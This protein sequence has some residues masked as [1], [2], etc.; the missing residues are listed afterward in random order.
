[1]KLKTIRLSVIAY[2]LTSLPVAGEIQNFSTRLQI[3]SAL[4]SYLDGSLG[5]PIMDGSAWKAEGSRV[6][7]SRLQERRTDNTPAISGSAITPKPVRW[8][9]RTG[10]AAAGYGAGLVIGIG[11]TR[12]GT[13]DFLHSDVIDGGKTASIGGLAGS[14]LHG[15]LR[16][17]LGTSGSLVVSVLVPALGG[18]LIGAKSNRIPYAWS[19]PGYTGFVTLGALAGAL[20][21][22][23]VRRFRNQ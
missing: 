22:E 2:F 10:E 8:Y 4:A 15:A 9:Q 19:R 17:R 18:W 3:H 13:G 12:K 11:V 16:D 6:S 7:G 14:I 23:G 20:T 1:M 21:T 5:I